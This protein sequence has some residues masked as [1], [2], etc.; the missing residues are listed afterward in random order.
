MLIFG[1]DIPLI[2]VIFILTIINF[3]LLIEV[4]V[5]VILLMQN[6]RKGKDLAGALG[7]LAHRS[8]RTKKK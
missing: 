5:V 8:V 1:V 7:G 4:I 3:I 2:E 6:L